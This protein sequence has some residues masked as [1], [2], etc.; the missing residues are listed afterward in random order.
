M[1]ATS[2]WARGFVASVAIGPGPVVAAED[3]PVAAGHALVQMYC[4]DCHATEI[5]GESPFPAAPR[6]RD[7]YLRY[8][9]QLLSEALVEGIVTAHAEMPQFEFD[10]D[11]AQA[12]I[13][14]LKSL[15]P[16]RPRGWQLDPNEQTGMSEDD[17]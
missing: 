5:A 17:Q 3:N 1:R 9:V 15:E 2:G 14:Y 7:L 16:F 11:Q 8:D 10:P 6:F 13:L 12:I 4:S